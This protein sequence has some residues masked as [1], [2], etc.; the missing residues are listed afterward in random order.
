MIEIYRDDLRIIFGDK[1]YELSIDDIKKFRY[2]KSLQN[3][4][5]QMSLD[6]I[7][8]LNQQHITEGLCVVDQHITKKQSLYEHEGDF[9]ITNI[10]RC[11]LVI[12]TADCLPIILYDA[13]NKVVG[14]VHAGWK[15]AYQGVVISAIKAMQEKYQSQLQDIDVLFGAAAQSC[16]YEVQEDF[17]KRFESYEYAQKAFVKRDN[18]LYFDNKQFVTSQLLIIGIKLKNIY[19]RHAT[20][21]ICSLQHC[22]FRRE[23][24][25]A[26]RQATVVSLW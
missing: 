17:Y 24:D 8:I 16:C 13:K 20:C 12:L 7:V 25:N 22:S 14:I 1:Q 2:A 5:A 23:K 6:S 19:D 11:G 10:K 3:I 21:T 18:K 4:V 9:L 26:G 15:G